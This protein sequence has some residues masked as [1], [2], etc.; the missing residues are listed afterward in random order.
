M[1]GY[2]ITPETGPAYG[3]LFT[4]PEVYDEAGQQVYV[5]QS[6]GYQFAEN[7][8]IEVTIKYEEDQAI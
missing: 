6:E 3:D 7:E 5:V 2:P 8:Q 4:S 1:I